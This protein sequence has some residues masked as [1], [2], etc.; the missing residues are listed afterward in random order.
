MHVFKRLNSIGLEYII[1]PDTLGRTRITHGDEYIIVDV[2][3][4]TISQ[5]WYDWEHKRLPI[6]SAF[7]CLGANERE[8]I[9]SG[10]TPKKWNEL[11]ANPEWKEGDE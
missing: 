5:C 10:I 8:F 3:P 2:S 7:K 6:Q 11:F 1:M 4:E 9:L